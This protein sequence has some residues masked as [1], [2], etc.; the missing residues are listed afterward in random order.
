MMAKKV[1]L[2][3]ENANTKPLN[4]RLDKA[5]LSRWDKFCRG[6]NTKQNL[7]AQALRE[8]MDREVIKSKIS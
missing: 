5:L 3:R 8:F 6:R 2:I 4:V 7:A 1:V